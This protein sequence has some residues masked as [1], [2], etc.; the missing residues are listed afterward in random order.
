MVSGIRRYPFAVIRSP[1]SVIRYPLSVIRY[2]LSVIRSPFAV[3]S[4]AE[5]WWADIIGEA[6]PPKIFRLAENLTTTKSV[7]VWGRSPRNKE[8]LSLAR[9]ILSNN[10]AVA[11]I[12][13][14]RD[15]AVDHR[16]LHGTVRFVQV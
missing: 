2:P 4:D 13:G 5:W 11:L 9:Q 10:R 14:S 7:G 6:N 8:A 12:P 15:L 3:W 1:L 16:G